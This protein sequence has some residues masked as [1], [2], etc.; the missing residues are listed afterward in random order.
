[1]EMKEGLQLETIH[2]SDEGRNNLKVV[3]FARKSDEVL[4]EDTD[5]SEVLV[6]TR[7]ELEESYQVNDRRAKDPYF[8]HIDNDKERAV[9]RLEFI[10]QLSKTQ[11]ETYKNPQMVNILAQLELLTADLEL[12]KEVLGDEHVTEEDKIESA[13]KAREGGSVFNT[14]H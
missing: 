6:I 11:A 13:I 12:H 14:N 8:G 1:M 5:T 7:T 3:M 10:H 9:K 2:H 4:V